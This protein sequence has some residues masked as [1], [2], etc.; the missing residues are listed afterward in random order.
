MK[1]KHAYL[2]IAHNN[3]YILKQLLELLD[4]ENNDIYIHMDKKTKNVDFAAFENICKKS[5][6]KFLRRRKSVRWGSPELVM[7]EMLLYREAYAHRPYAY[8]HLLSGTDLPLKS[9]E[10]IHKF[11][12]EQTQDFI[13][14]EKTLTKSN[15]DRV[16]KYNFN[17]KYSRLYDL[18]TKL[19]DLLRIDRVKKY[20]LEIKKGHQ[21]A[22][23]TEQSV[24]ILIDNEKFIKKFIRFSSCADEIYKQTILFAKGIEPY[25]SSADFL[26]FTDWINN[27]NHPKIL[28]SEDFDRI[29]RSG[30]FFA[31]KFDESTDTRVVKMVAEAV[32]AAEAVT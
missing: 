30:A 8:Y 26:R 13:F 11:F 9:Q 5:T 27:E 14:C 28:T 29:M 16:S 10:E 25:K 32:R 23:L 1:G 24:K 4:H 3:F 31:R 6:V 21:W 19:Q 20:G 12:D 18:S 15:R 2:I 17:L 7:A 22:S